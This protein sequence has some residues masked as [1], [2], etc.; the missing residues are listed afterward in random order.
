MKLRALVST[1]LVAVVMTG[2][3]GGGGEPGGPGTMTVSPSASKL[4]Y[5]LTSNA[6]GDRV[7]EN[8][9][10]TPATL[11]G[12]YVNNFE[13]FG[14]K[15]PVEISLIDEVRFRL[16]MD[17]T[18]PRKFRLFHLGGCSSGAVVRVIEAGQ[19]QFGSVSVDVSYEKSTSTP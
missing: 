18:N 14:G 9:S 7:V 15:S 13:V 17:A 16:E 2:C 11:S 8:P 12:A 10:C 4:E 19:V 5:K 1:A 3:G 6:S